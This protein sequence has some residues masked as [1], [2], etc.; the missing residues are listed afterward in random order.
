MQETS[1]LTEREQEILHRMGFYEDIA[2]RQ[3]M[4]ELRHK[5]GIESRE[6]FGAMDFAKNQ[7]LDVKFYLGSLRERVQT[8]TSRQ[9]TPIRV[10]GKFIA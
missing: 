3:L 1:E 4:I 7:G 8:T 9:L 2:L 6:V 5:S 10:R